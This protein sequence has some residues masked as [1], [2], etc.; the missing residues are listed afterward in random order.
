MAQTICMPLLQE[1]TDVWRPVQAEPLGGELFRVL[2]EVPEEEMWKF[3]PGTIV[4][5]REQV[6]DGGRRDLAAYATA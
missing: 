5:C 3:P 4:L 6:F 1:G 2:G